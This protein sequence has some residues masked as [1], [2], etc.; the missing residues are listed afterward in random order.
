MNISNPSLLSTISADLIINGIADE[1][2]M[3]RK[4]EISNRNLIVNDILNGYLVESKLTCPIRYLL[5]PDYFTGKSFEICALQAGVQ[6]FGAERFTVGNKPAEKAA[7][8]SVITPSTIN[9]LTEGAQRL[10]K[11]LS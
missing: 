4:K 5:L 7:R 2:I 10:K 1:I 11:I 6:V 9:D 8:I 3:E